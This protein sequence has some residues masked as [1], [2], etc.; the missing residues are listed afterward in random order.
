MPD[1]D[2]GLHGWRAFDHQ[3][4]PKLACVAARQRGVVSRGQLWELGLSRGQVRRLLR[5]GWLQPVHRN[6]YAVGHGHLSDWAHLFAALLTFGPRAFL[7]HRTAAGVW[8]LRPVNLHDIEVTLPGTGGRAREG[9]T[10]HRTHAEPPPDEVR[11]HG[12]LR[13]S[14][15][16]RMLVEL[17]ARETP[18]ELAR[19]VTVAVQKRLLRLDARDGRAAME[20][21]LARH[22]RRPGMATLTAVLAA[23]R[24]TESSKSGLELA[25]DGLLAAHPELPQP[26]RNIQIDHW[27]ID[28]FWPDHSLAVELD[29]RPYHIAAAAME[30]DR[31]K[32]AWLL[33]HGVTPLRFTDFRVEHDPRGILGDLRHFLKLG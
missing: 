14:S 23:Y 5:D 4:G 26:L 32:D 3:S 1:S 20:A 9:L 27:E 30:K 21:V 18:A 28:R 17:A 11:P 2:G 13:A 19:L 12:Q 8:K 24:R 33:K 10:V 15:V 31:I 29:G 7:S 22:E 25:F 16:P 6:V